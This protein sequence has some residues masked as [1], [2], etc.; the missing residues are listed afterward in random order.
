MRRLLHGLLACLLWCSLPAEAYEPGILGTTKGVRHQAVHDDVRANMSCQFG[1][2][3]K[4]LPLAEVIERILCQD[5]QTRLS[6]AHAKIQAAQVGLS[7]SA[8]LPRLDGRLSSGQTDRFGGAHRRYDTASLELSWVLFDFGRRSA[9]MRN[10]HQLLLAANANQDATLQNAFAQ[11]AQIYYDAQAAERRLTA[12]VQIANLATQNLDAA[13]ARYKA[14]T[15]AISERLQAQ[16]ALSQAHLREV[17]DRGALHNAI[18]TIALRMGL[19][20]NVPLQLAVDPTPLPDTHFVK[21]ID[22]LLSQAHQEH[23]ALLAARAQLQAANAAVEEVRAT[24]LPSVAFTADLSQGRNMTNGDTGE[25]SHGIGLQLTIPLFDGFGRTYQIRNA[26]ARV[27]AEQA[28]LANAEQQVAL[29]LWTHYQTLSTET[30]S[31]QRTSEL[32]DQSRQALEVIQGRYHSGVGSM[33][34]VLNALT[35]YAD[36]EE[37]HTQTLNHWQTSRLKLIASLGQLGF[38]AL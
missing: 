23:P 19:S 28:N 4:Q 22:K 30:Q 3:P 25:Q 17:R 34:E 11:A 18:G 5:P 7:Q 6:W 26:K 20:P 27:E 10:A 15:T 1:Q 16:T 36:A 35:A 21:A 29:D 13:D 9:A 24:G 38:W 12:S 31:L 14:G 37:Q 33:V 8:Y 2:L 32:V